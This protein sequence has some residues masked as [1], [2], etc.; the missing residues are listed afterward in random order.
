MK[1]IFTILSFTLTFLTYSQ[2]LVISGAGTS[3]AN[4]TY[5]QNGMLNGKPNYLGPNSNTMFWSTGLFWIIKSPNS[6]YYYSTNNVATPDLVTNW[7]LDEDGSMPLP[8]VT[9][10]LSIK[11]FSIDQVKIY[12]NPTTNLINITGLTN[13]ESYTIFDVM[14]RTLLNGILASNNTINLENLTNGNYY[15]K[16]SNGLTY[17]IL[18]K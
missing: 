9:G 11:D 8:Q 6:S 3:S 5:I 17:T 14:G 4:G 16:L 13:T 15:L 1:K 10:N 18:K 2:N 7:L 12:P